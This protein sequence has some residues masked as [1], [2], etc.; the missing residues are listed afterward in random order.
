MAT[1]KL[2]EN[3]IAKK[4]NGKRRKRRGRRRNPSLGTGSTK[5]VVRRNG[6]TTK[7]GAASFAKRNGLKLVKRTNGKRKHHRRKRRNGVSAV[8][9]VSNGIFGTGS[10]IVKK[11]LTLTGGAI[12]TNIGGNYIAT[13]LSPYLSQFGLGQYTDLITQALVAYFGVPYL[14]RLLKQDAEMA[15]LGGFLSVT[16]TALNKFFPQF[17]SLNP[18][19]NSA[20]VV[21]P[22]GQIALTG[23]AVKQVAAAAAADTAAKVSGFADQMY[24]MNTTQA[25]PTS[26]FDV[27]AIH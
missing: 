3:G 9:R 23:D 16:L 6:R 4:A 13:M 26:M 21:N 15:R 7:A 2:I 18:F 20:I 8:R 11:T 25:L 17:A 5:R 22:N 12:A 27:N 14:A 1:L 19:A 24:A 10:S